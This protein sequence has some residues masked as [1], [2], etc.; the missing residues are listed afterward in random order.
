LA[1]PS[2][3]IGIFRTVETVLVCIGRRFGAVCGAGLDE[4]VADVTGD[5]VEADEQ[6]FAD[7]AVRHARRD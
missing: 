4:D 7:L 1:D 3:G 6:L 5:G 2:T